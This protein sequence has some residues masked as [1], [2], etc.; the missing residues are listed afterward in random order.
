MGHMNRTLKLA[1]LSVL[2][3][4]MF[5]PAVAQD[6]FPD[7]PENHWAYEALENMKREGIL[8]GYLDGLYRGSRTATRYEIAMAVNAA[9]Q[10]LRGL[11]DG[12]DGR[13]RELEEQIEAGEA[14]DLREMRDALAALRRD[15]DGMRAWGDDVAALRRMA[16]TFERELA[17]LGVDVEAM[18]RDLE[19]IEARVQRLEEAKFP[20]EISGDANIFVAAGNSRS[21][22]PGMT[23]DGRIIGVNVQ[24]GA[25]DDFDLPTVGLTRDL[26]V[27]HEFAVTL[28]GTNEEGPKWNATLVHGNMTGVDNDTG[29]PVGFGDQSRRQGGWA[30]RQG[31]GEFYIQNLEVGFDTSLVGIPFNAKVGRLGAQFSSHLFKRVDNTPYFENRRWD[32]GNWMVDGAAL[33]F[34]F[35]A[36]NLV[37]LGGRTSG[38][39]TSGGTELQPVAFRD[40]A[41]GF[42]SIDTT[43]GAQL[44]FP[45]GDL[46]DLK[47]AYLF[48]DTNAVGINPATSAN[49]LNVYGA[50]LDLS[51]DRIKING[52]YGIS[53][54][55]YNTSGIGRDR[56]NQFASVKVGFDGGAWDFSAGYRRIQGDYQAAGTWERIGT[57]WTPTGIEGFSVGANVKLTDAIALSYRGEFGNTISPQPGGAG[58]IFG[59]GVPDD[60]DFLSNV[61]EL[62]YRVNDAWTATLG[63]EEV[64][65]RVAGSDIRQRWA[66]LGLGYTL[67]PNASLR[68][69]YEYGSVQNQAFR[70]GQGSARPGRR[71]DF[72]GGFLTTQLSIRF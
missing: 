72:R 33:T 56:N 14:A 49:R 57:Y 71:G 21:R 15:V 28:R 65:V 41:T 58:P 13:I 7:V 64:Q 27:Y 2:T 9:F 46:G 24:G 69:A 51:L 59:N 47:L 18:K 16:E 19:G 12:L 42:R 40:P 8:V 60:V 23:K 3:A 55:T 32:D 52:K 29:G 61:G 17:S 50:E 67:G 54:P 68:F 34:D 37:V 62:R 1:L 44:A 63:Y 31:A 4:A 6:N 20:V 22:A 5:V 10:R 39:E 30:F 26:G 66:T 70:W 48:H 38:R 45:I 36:A 43:L 53:T 25:P 11:T 35:G